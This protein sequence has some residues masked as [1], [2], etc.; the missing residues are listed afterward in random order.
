MEDLSQ[1]WLRIQGTL[2][3]FL[4]GELGPISTKQE[5][6]I[7]ILELLHIERFV[8]E[9]GRGWAGRPRQDRQALARAFVAKALYNMN[10]TRELVERLDSCRN[11]RRI[12]GW[13]RRD[14][15]PVESTFSR[16]FSEFAETRLAEQVNVS[17]PIQTAPEKNPEKTPAQL[18]EAAILEHCSCDGVHNLL[19]A[20]GSRMSRKRR[21]KS[22]FQQ[23]IRTTQ[24]NYRALMSSTIDLRPKPQAR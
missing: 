4:Q 18:Q 23:L 19:F 24:L 17:L 22:H 20:I 10:T 11:L 9:V 2:F 3:P 6:L 7:A 12:C 5:K 15:I 8:Q 21:T 1:V 16:A 14:E 13:E